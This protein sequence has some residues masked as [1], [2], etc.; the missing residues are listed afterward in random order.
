MAN[1]KGNISNRMDYYAYE[2][3]KSIMKVNHSTD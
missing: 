2:P 3:F 1:L